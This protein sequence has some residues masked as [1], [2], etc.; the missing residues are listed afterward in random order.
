MTRRGLARLAPALVRLLAFALGCAGASRASVSFGAQ[1]EPAA[2][3]RGLLGVATPELS[4][5]VRRDFELSIARGLRFGGLDVVAD[6]TPGGAAP[7]LLSCGNASCFRELGAA[8]GAGLVARAVIE[9]TAVRARESSRRNYSIKVQVVSTRSGQSLVERGTTCESCAS[10]VA[11]HLGYLM[12]ID[13]GQ[14]LNDLRRPV[15]AT[16][17]R[18]APSPTVAGPRTAA[19][20]AARTAS[21]VASTKPSTP[22][23]NKPSTNAST[24]PG[25]VEIHTVVDRGPA[26]RHSQL[27]KV[28][29]G[30]LGGLG[31]AAVTTGTV[32]WARGQQ[33]TCSDR[34]ASACGRTYTD[35]PT[36]WLLTDLGAAAIVGAIIWWM[37]PAPVANGR[38]AA[39]AIGPGGFVVRGWF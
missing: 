16:A 35:A 9:S 10:D 22:P 19:A 28:G 30:V 33:S 18:P 1:G 14:R 26:P 4:D 12:A 34:P 6:P 24:K 5:S 31:L 32:L 8:R 7:D 21:V 36:G 17:A 20:P 15:V 27:T 3:N 13:V 37:L 25:I 29:V 39:V 11:T 2:S 38:T 23:T